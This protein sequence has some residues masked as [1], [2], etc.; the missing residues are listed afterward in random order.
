MLPTPSDRLPFRTP[1]TAIGAAA[2]RELPRLPAPEKNSSSFRGVRSSLLFM[3]PA[4]RAG[5]AKVSV[6]SCVKDFGGQL[7]RLGSNFA[8]V[9]GALNQV[10]RLAAFWRPLFIDVTSQHVCD[11]V[12]INRQAVGVGVAVEDGG[13]SVWVRAT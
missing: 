7:I 6:P 5:N 12:W 2:L 9:K 8:E 1:R 4:F 3:Q 13:V 10:A 11:E